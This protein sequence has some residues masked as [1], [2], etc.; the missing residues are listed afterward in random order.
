MRKTP[1]IGVFSAVAMM[2]CTVAA[3]VVV[4]AS[5]NG[6]VES[7]KVQPAVLLAIISAVSN[8]AFGS[9]LATGIAV[10]FWLY[11]SRDGAHQLSQLHYIWDHGR[12]LGFIPA[13]RAGR[14]ARTVALLATLAYVAQFASGPFWQR[15]VHQGTVSRE[16]PQTLS[17]DMS[18]HIQDGLLG[19]IEN[20]TSIGFRKG[21]TQVQQ[22]FR[23]DTIVTHNE[24]GYVCEDGTCYGVVRGAGIAHRCTTRYAE[25][26]MARTDNNGAT[27]FAINVT[28]TANATGQPDFRML[29]LHVDSVNNSCVSHITIDECQIDAAVVEY[30]VVVQNTT[31]YLELEN[32]TRMHV[33]STSWTPD[34]LPTA[35]DGAGAGLLSALHAMIESNYATDTVKLFKA[36]SNPQVTVYG[37]DGTLAD[38]FVRTESPYWDE[39]APTHKC[40]I[41]WDSPTEYLL[42]EVHKFMFRTALRFGNNT[43]TQT[44]P[45]QRVVILTV[46]KVDTLYLGA[47]AAAMACSFAF[48]ACLMRGWWR[49]ARPVTL[50]P[51][52]TAGAVLRAPV[53]GQDIAAQDRPLKNILGNLKAAEV[54]LCK[55]VPVTT[56][57]PTSPRADSGTGEYRDE[58]ASPRDATVEMMAMS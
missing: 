28:R 18:R 25:L 47:A 39:G 30:P 31:V 54:G 29:V 55:T 49:L 27:V 15:S 3:G 13:V 4:A 46:F 51:L 48:V 56:S 6:P 53:L 50:S 44:F 12:G 45:T 14:R 21:V 34:D 16:T 57:A 8:I 9:A 43:E 1:W 33:V 17:M 26:E 19:T 20:G 58:K 2:V 38:L 42:R 24:E 41:S 23:N 10:Q 36:A 22:N 35:P 7:W 5:H 52:E 32:L 37:G 40:A 11:A